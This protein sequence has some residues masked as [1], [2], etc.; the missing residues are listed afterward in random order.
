M[1]NF[2]CFLR[3]PAEILA[4][5]ALKLSKIPTKRENH[6]SRPNTLAKC[7]SKRIKISKLSS[8]VFDHQ[9]VVTE[10]YIRNALYVNS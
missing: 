10:V 3:L 8:I 9:N 7:N 5:K 1:K 2:I 6:A 4:R